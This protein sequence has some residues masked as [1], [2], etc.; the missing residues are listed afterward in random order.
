MN[1]IADFSPLDCEKHFAPKVLGVQHLIRIIPD[2]DLDFCY[3]MSSL[4]TISGGVKFAAYAAANSYLNAVAMH[5]DTKGTTKWLSINWDGWLYDHQKDQPGWVGLENILITPSEGHLILNELFQTDVGP[6]V[7]VSARDFAARLN[8]WHNIFSYPFLLTETT[9]S[10]SCD[11]TPDQIRK[12]VIDIWEEGLGI[13]GIDSPGHFLEDLTID[14]QVNF[15]CNSPGT[16][17]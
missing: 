6:V 2:Q 14:A 8:A 10:L 3:L 4:S 5:Y 15:I 1:K 9:S 16:S 7:V 13:N 17:S 11:F 12:T